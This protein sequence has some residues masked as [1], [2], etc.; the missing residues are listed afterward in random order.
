MF[1][2]TSCA[3]ITLLLASGESQ[4]A[5]ISE[6]GSISPQQ[7]RKKAAEA[8]LLS[9][10]NHPAGPVTSLRPITAQS[11]FSNT[12][13]ALQLLELIYEGHSL[14]AFW[15]VSMKDYKEA[16]K[17][18]IGLSQADRK[19][20]LYGEIQPPSFMQLLQHIGARP[21]QKY[22]DLGSGTGKTV[23]AAWL[24]GLDATGVELVDKRWKTGCEAVIKSKGLGF[25]KK[26]NGVNF[27]HDNFLK[28]DFSDADIIFTDS[29]MFSKE[30]MLGL[31]DIARRMKPN[32]KLIST[33][34]F[35]G[36]GFRLDEKILAPTSWSTGTTFTV[37]T[38]LPGADKYA[39]APLPNTGS[40]SLVDG[41]RP[42]RHIM[43]QEGPLIGAMLP[44][45]DISSVTTGKTCSLPEGTTSGMAAHMDRMA[46]APANGV[47]C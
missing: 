10:P 9:I 36:E 26:S 27:V 22:V 34:G 20:I 45:E 32:S 31:A 25:A 4:F 5:E 33:S 21:G 35:P 24:L 19:A 2:Y 1:R 14:H 46:H 6:S 47:V 40:A 39:K 38:V 42:H 28:M 15:K 30:M 12:S 37:Q 17:E 44:T 8:P 16:D 41:V 23:F 13:D 43:R 7:L 3:V 18:M 29:A 11:G